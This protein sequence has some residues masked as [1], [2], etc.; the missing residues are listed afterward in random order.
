MY[1]GSMAFAGC[2]G[3]FSNFIPKGTLI[4]FYS[5][6]IVLSHNDRGVGALIVNTITQKIGGISYKMNVLDLLGNVSKPQGPPVLC[7]TAVWCHKT[8]SW[9]HRGVWRS[10]GVW[11][12]SLNCVVLSRSTWSLET[13]SNMEDLVVILADSNFKVQKGPR[14]GNNP[15]LRESK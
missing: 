12:T 14:I 9:R 3:Y 10:L 11:M 6:L 4:I 1:I 7:N 5:A 2:S 15:F 8:T 13:S